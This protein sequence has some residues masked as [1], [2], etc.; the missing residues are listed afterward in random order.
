[1]ASHEFSDDHAGLFRVYARP[2]AHIRQQI[3]VG[4]F[5]LIFGAGAGYDLGFPQWIG[6]LDRLGEGL[7]GYQDAIDSAEN[8]VILAQLLVVLCY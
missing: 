8:A 5:C 2:V 4:R 3:P 6:L 1:M 7:D